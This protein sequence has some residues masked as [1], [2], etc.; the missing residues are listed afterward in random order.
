MAMLF[1]FSL[2]FETGYEKEKHLSETTLTNVLNI[3]HERNRDH[4]RTLVDNSVH[5]ALNAIS[6]DD[7]ATMNSH[8]IIES[9]VDSRFIPSE[10][11]VHYKDGTPSIINE[12]GQELHIS[13]PGRNTFWFE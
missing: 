11:I 4:M 2:G 6:P 12:R 9:M 7:L 8:E 3:E 5:N 1:T 10:F 13:M